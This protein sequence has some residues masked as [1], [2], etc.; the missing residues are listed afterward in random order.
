MLTARQCYGPQ[1]LRL[2][3][4]T[5]THETPYIAVAMIEQPPVFLILHYSG[6]IDR[7]NG[8]QTH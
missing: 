1:R 2:I 8:A 4:L 5:I 7:L 3:A 6:L